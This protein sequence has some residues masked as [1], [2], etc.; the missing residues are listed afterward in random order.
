MQVIRIF[1]RLHFVSKR[2][3]AQTEDS[4]VEDSQM[5]CLMWR[6]P[7]HDALN[8]NSSIWDVM[9]T[10]IRPR[11]SNQKHQKNLGPE[12]PAMNRMVSDFKALCAESQSSQPI[13]RLIVVVQK[14]TLVKGVKLSSPMAS[15][16]PA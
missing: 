8:L 9:C 12:T 3:L 16:L 15:S 11:Q 6:V 7:R 1:D 13:A 5:C 2:L 14:R 4:I 10:S